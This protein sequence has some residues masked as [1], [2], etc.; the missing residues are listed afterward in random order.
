M[1]KCDHINIKGAAQ[2]NLRNI[3][4]S[5]PKHKLVVVT[6]VSGSGKSSLAFDT[7]YAEG[8]RRYAEN[9]SSRA[10]FFLH[11]IKK[12]KIKRIE[13][14]S[15]AIAID[16]KS[17]A[18]NPRSTV[19]TV[20]DVYDFFRILFSEVGIPHCP[21]CNEKLQKQDEKQLMK[22]IRKMD[23]GTQ[24]VVLGA[25]SGAQKTAKEKLTVIKGQ[26][27]SKV[28]IEE[29]IMLAEQVKVDQLKG[30]EKIQVVIDR[31]T[32]NPSK[33]D[34][35]RV[36][37]SLQT[38][39]K[40]SKGE[41]VV[42]IDNDQELK[43]SKHYQCESCNFVLK[44][45]SAK[46]FS[47]NSPSGACDRCSGLGSVFQV[48]LEKVL[49]NK[50]LSISEGAIM[51]WS[52]AGGRANGASQHTQILIALAKKYKFSLK[53]PIKKIPR[54]KLEKIIYGT[55][56]E[57]IVVK[58]TSKSSKEIHF[59][60]LAHE[61]EEKY[62]T[63]DSSYV[64]NEIER[65]LKK[66]I[67]PTC[68]GMRLKTAFL[69]VR[70]MDKRISDVVQMEIDDLIS[71]LEENN[72]KASKELDKSSF[73]IMK[74]LLDEISSRLKP[75]Q[76]VG[77]GYLSLD[78][79]T[80]TL[81]GGEFQ[82]VRLATQLYSGLSDVV[83]VLDEPS[84]GLHTRDTKRLIDTLNKLKERG[85][86][87]V[88]VEH[89][90]DIIEAADYVIDIGPKAGKEGGKVVFAGTC[91]ELKRS[92]I[93]TSQYLFRDKKCKQ[94]S[95]KKNNNNNLIIKGASQNN[96][97]NIDVTLPLGRLVSVVG[98]S[99]SGK[100]SLVNDIMAK[101]LRKTIHGSHEDAGFHKKIEGA[102]KLAKVVIVDQASIG[103]SPRS[104]AAT[105]TGVFSHIRKLFASAELAKK[106]GFTS[107]HFSFN[108]RGGRCEYC[109]GEGVRKIEMHLLNNVYADCPHCGGTRYNKK[110]LEVQHHGANIVDVLDMSIEYAHHFF[111]SN[112]LIADKLKALRDVGLGYLRLGQSA[113][114]LSGGEAQRIK[115]ATELARKSNGNTLYILDEPTIGLHFSDVC[116]LLK[117]LEGLVNAGNSVVVVE[118][119]T[120]VI[121]ASDWIIELGPD[122][123]QE[124]GDIVFEGTPSQLEKA[125]TWTGKMM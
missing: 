113:T 80:Q 36:V 7:L 108:M 29:K 9:L 94:A 97:K 12:P 90:R 98:V 96:L 42:L 117:V 115:L 72:K 13:N 92:K 91:K 120:D 66:K 102:H 41:A 26:G 95:S 89:D 60:G 86:S 104:N 106:K 54:E 22:K 74:Q 119:N 61:L 82:R 34:R 51:P 3:D 67:C 57:A 16:Q 69:N 116:Q 83:Y 33:F 122:G 71:F 10:R 6:G 44:S 19:G 8:Y 105:Y 76:D 64:R 4:V 52:R 5:I 112:K 85:N 53:V 38:A 17:D 32:L 118:H 15:P 11:S 87:I 93:Q 58:Q 46:N 63:A 111:N 101:A 50:S 103:R 99:G 39:T 45:I 47:F 88:V 109:Q 68:E 79:N 40:I 125:K 73:M 62:K 70:V 107:S 55:G 30:D 56:E 81:S 31:I 59:K 24:V 100:S 75:L 43:Y 78:R 49:P 114:A 14:L 28:R 84:V 65:Y 21:H 110:M 37:D 1:V 23:A 121:R 18:H 35:E 77:V 20:T 2:N 48:D 124:G 25:W 123:G 27:Y